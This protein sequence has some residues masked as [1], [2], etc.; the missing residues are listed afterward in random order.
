MFT[1]KLNTIHFQFGSDS[2]TAHSIYGKDY[3]LGA[4]AK[5]GPPQ[6]IITPAAGQVNLHSKSSIIVL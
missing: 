3:A 5:R 4:M 2:N 1:S 6:K